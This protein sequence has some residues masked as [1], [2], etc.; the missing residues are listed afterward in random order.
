MLWVAILVA[1]CPPR[2]S[3]KTALSDS[4]L[5]FGQTTDLPSL[6]ARIRFDQTYWSCVRQRVAT[7]SHRAADA[8]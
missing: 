6:K 8:H 3:A 4:L 2:F 1:L 7:L 5:A